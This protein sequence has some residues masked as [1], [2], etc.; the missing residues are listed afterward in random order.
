MKI[1][2]VLLSI[3]CMEL[4]PAIVMA[5]DDPYATIMGGYTKERTSKADAHALQIYDAWADDMTNQIKSGKRKGL[6]IDSVD[7]EG[8]GNVTIEKGARVTGPIIVKPEIDNST[9]IFRS[10]KTSRF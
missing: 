3:Y 1:I 2:F 4:Q 6:I 5:D 7:P 10:D 9:V 8:I